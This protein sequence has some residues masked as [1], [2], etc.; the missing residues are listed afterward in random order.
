MSTPRSCWNRTSAPGLQ[1]LAGMH[2]GCPLRGGRRLDVERLFRH[3]LQKQA[4]DGAAAGN[5]VA[6]ES[7]R[8]NAGIVDDEQVAGAEES[9]QV[10]DRR[11]LVR[12]GRSVYDE[13]PGASAGRGLLRN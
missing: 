6:E 4:L 11:M 9:W 5:A 3:A 2:E 7:G 12:A 10:A 13:Q 1:F 8:K